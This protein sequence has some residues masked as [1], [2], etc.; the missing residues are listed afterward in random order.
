MNRFKLALLY[1]VIAFSCQTGAM[2]RN[3]IEALVLNNTGEEIRI[4]FRDPQKLA[5][6]TEYSKK[7]PG[8]LGNKGEISID[9]DKESNFIQRIKPA[10]WLGIRNFSYNDEIAAQRV[11]GGEELLI[12]RGLHPVWDQPGTKEIHVKLEPVAAGLPASSV[13]YAKSWMPRKIGGLIPPPQKQ[14]KLVA[15]VRV[16]PKQLSELEK[17]EEV[18]VIAEKGLPATKEREEK[19]EAGEVKTLEQQKTVFEKF[20]EKE[21]A[22]VKAGEIGKWG[23]IMELVFSESSRNITEAEIYNK[24]GFKKVPTA[25][26]LF[27]P[28]L[29]GAPE[30][31]PKQ[32]YRKLAKRFSY[33]YLSLGNNFFASVS[34][35]KAS[36]VHNLILEAGKKLK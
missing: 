12:S 33:D 20:R 26:Q 21:L 28:V 15:E 30:M 8:R 2:E 10:G 36:P 14:M 35:D 1:S 18:T 3:K 19:R 11:S 13:E 27:D 22:A 29:Y 4:E 25:E 23:A 5:R 9:A 34:R 31:T 32:V 24:L 16:N 7:F 17:V 6:Y